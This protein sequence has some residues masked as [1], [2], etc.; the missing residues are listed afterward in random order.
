MAGNLVSYGERI[1][2]VALGALILVGPPVFAI[3]IIATGLGERPLFAMTTETYTR[4]VP[5]GLLVEISTPLILWTLIIIITWGM[6]RGHF[7]RVR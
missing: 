1:L 5:S 6:H 2:G 7:P 3:Y 4:T